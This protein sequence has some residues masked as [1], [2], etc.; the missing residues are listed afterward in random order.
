MRKLNLPA[1]IKAAPDSGVFTGYASVFGN[2]DLGGDI[3]ERGAF[4]EFVANRDGR[5]VVLWQH[6]INA[7]IGTATVRQDDRGLAFE[8]ELVLDDD[9]ARSALAHMRAR[10]VEGMSIGF[11]ILP[12]GQRYREDGA[13]VLTALKLW[14]ISVVTWGM[15]PLAGVEVA[16]AANIRELEGMLRDALC[17]SSRR[18]KAAAAALWPVLSAREAQGDDREDR[19]AE[20]LGRLAAQVHSLNDLLKGT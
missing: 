3:V 18:S 6:D 4:K 13:R 17:L 8:G 10:S 14:E 5:V 19:E 20:V 9:K 15:N 7:P 2:V 12:G 1:E 11:D 16:K